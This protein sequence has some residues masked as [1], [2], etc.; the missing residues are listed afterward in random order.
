MYNNAGVEFARRWLISTLGLTFASVPCAYHIFELNCF[1]QVSD[2]SEVP[3]DIL[4]NGSKVSPE[5]GSLLIWTEHLRG[6]GH[7][8]IVTEVMHAD[9]CIRIAEQNWDD[10]YWPEGRDYGRQLS[11]RVDEE[12]RMWVEDRHILGWINV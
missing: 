4:P 12:E 8:A 7:V 2:N 1:Q 11:I 10:K 5:V 6:T 9:H 3:I